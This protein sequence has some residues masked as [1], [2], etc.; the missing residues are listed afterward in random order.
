MP[1]YYPPPNAT[2]TQGFLELAT[3]TNFVTDGLL[4]PLLLLVIWVVV[5]VATKQFT[6]SKAFTY[7]SFIGLILGIPLTILGLV[8]PRYIY[9]LGILLATGLVWLKLEAGG[10]PF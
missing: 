6:V 8:S 1:Q 7:S 3:Y 9:V 2:D 5:F 4:F 10:K